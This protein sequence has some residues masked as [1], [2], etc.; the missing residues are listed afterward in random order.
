MPASFHFKL[1]PCSAV[2]YSKE[3]WGPDAHQWKPERW[4]TPAA[5]EMEKNWLVVRISEAFRYRIGFD[6]GSSRRDI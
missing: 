6:P 2:H 4:M 5:R 3:V 1:T